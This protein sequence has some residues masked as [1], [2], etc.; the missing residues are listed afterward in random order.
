MKKFQQFLIELVFGLVLLLCLFYVPP[1]FNSD[2]FQE[3]T[4][5]HPYALLI[6]LLGTYL[7]R[8][9]FKLMKNRPKK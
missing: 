6:A 1:L 3:G 8:Y 2:W 9:L 5:S 4:K 7:I